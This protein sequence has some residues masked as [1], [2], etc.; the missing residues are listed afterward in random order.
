L[1]SPP[2]TLLCASTPGPRCRFHVTAFLWTNGANRSSRSI[3]VVSHH[4]D[5]LLRTPSLKL[6]SA[7]QLLGLVA[8]RSRPWGSLRFYRLPPFFPAT[9]LTA[10]WSIWAT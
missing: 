7:S 6:P 3:L 4:L 1:N 5:G 8:S 10:A 9:A 2:P